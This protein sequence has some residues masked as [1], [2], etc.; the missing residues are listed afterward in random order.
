MPVD[1]FSECR[2]CLLADIRVASEIYRSSPNGKIHGGRGEKNSFDL[3]TP[4]KIS[5]QRYRSLKYALSLRP[6]NNTEIINLCGPAF[7]WIFV[8]ELEGPKASD[9]DE[10][11]SATLSS[12][13]WMDDK[14]YILA[15]SYGSQGIR[16][17]SFL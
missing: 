3:E 12:I 6:S 5:N 13:S 8:K 1:V 17:V 15:S 14:K 2:S 16:F 11:P 10:G 4:P 7:P 9:G